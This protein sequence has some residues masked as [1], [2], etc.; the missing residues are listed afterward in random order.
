MATSNVRCRK[1]PAR[2]MA[3]RPALI[4]DLKQRGT[5]R[6]DA[7]SSGAANSERT[8]VKDRNGNATP[9]R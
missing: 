1:E 8:V 9:G 2:S 3:Q 4:K 5:A 7:E 6:L